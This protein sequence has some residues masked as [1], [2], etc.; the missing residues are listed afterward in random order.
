MNKVQNCT[1]TTVCQPPRGSPAKVHA[2]A[3]RNNATRA[4]GFAPMSACQR[5]GFATK[6]RGR[7][8]ASLGLSR[9]G[10]FYR[11]WNMKKGA[12][13]WNNRGYHTP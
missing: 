7:P 5:A 8:R 4:R 1:A 9:Q 3:N 6:G 13:N 2:W 11:V 12:L 10:R